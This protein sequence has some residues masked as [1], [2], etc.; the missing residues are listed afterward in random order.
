MN[1]RV[2]IIFAVITLGFVITGCGKKEVKEDRP[3]IKVAFWGTPEEVEIIENIIEPWQRTHPQ[4]KVELEHTPFSGYVNK[5]LTRVAG[6]SAPDIICAEAN[7]FASFWGKNIL[8]FTPTG[9]L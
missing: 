8:N 9:R 5:I 7:L 4:I 2:A 3:T 6:G 1:S